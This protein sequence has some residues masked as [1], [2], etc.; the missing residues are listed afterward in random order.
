MAFQLARAAVIGA[1]TM[2]AAIAAHLANAGVPVDLLDIAPDRLTPEEE[3]RGLTLEHPAVR[4]RIV[5]AGP[6]R[7]KNARPPSF[8]SQAAQRL[9]RPGNLVD[10]VERLRAADW[11]VEAI[12][13]NLE[14]KQQLMARLEGVVKPDAIVSSNTN[15]IPIHRIAAGRSEA[16]R[17]RFLG[18]HFFNPPRYLKLLELI[19][20]DDTDPEVV[21]AMRRIGP[22]TLGKGVVVCKDT[23]N[24]IGNRIAGINGTRALAYEL[25]HGYTVEEVDAIA[26]PL[27]GRPRSATFRLQDIV[28]LMCRSRSGAT[29]TPPSRTTSRARC[30]A[31][32]TWSRSRRR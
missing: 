31:T 17:R 6:E 3:R 5:L 27:I 28:G 24:F 12:V 7:A 4:N 18:T 11:I 32:R 8:M 2:G 10:D 16:F 9:V 21:E 15:G 1:G 26:G 22:E 13:E 19:P 30:C 20:T 14:V 23:P 29:S 25:A